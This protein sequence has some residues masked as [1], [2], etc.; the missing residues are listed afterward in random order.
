MS[1]RR[2]LRTA[3][4]A[5]ATLAAACTPAPPSP[6]HT[7]AATAPAAEP[8]TAPS[9]PAPAPTPSPSAASAPASAPA[10]VSGR[11]RQQLQA[12]VE[13]STHAIDS[14]HLAGEDLAAALCTRAEALGDLGG[15]ADGAD[16]GALAAGLADAA[17]ALEL[18]P[19]LAR[20]WHCRGVLRWMNGDFAAAAL[21][22]GEALARGHD[23]AEALLRRGQ[24]RFY[25]GQLAAAAADFAQAGAQQTDET[26]RL[27]AALW[28]ATALLRLAQ[29]LPPALQAMAAQAPDGDWPRPA[30]ALLAGLRS[31]DALLAWAAQRPAGDERTLTL[32]EAWFHIGQQR[33][34][35]GRPAAAREAFEA[36]RAQGVPSNPEHVAARFELQRLAR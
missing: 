9:S 7:A 18:A 1:P 26:G 2:S 31:A 8:A 20:A 19:A 13:R 27:Y 22:F 3:A 24:A 4:L 36:V 6:S 28:Q 11:L 25:D 34:A 12:T 33:L 15:L 32:A 17:R 29:P 30:L 16:R 35:Q 21:D 23:A 10:P 5:L 14:G